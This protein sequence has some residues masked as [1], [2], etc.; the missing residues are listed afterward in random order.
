MTSG[1][2]PRVRISPLPPPHLPLRQTKQKKHFDAPAP[3]G[4]RGGGK[5][6]E[7]RG[8][9]GTPP[10]RCPRRFS[11]TLFPA[12]FQNASSFRLLLKLAV[13]H[14]HTKRKFAIFGTCDLLFLSSLSQFWGVR[15]CSRHI[16]SRS[17]SLF[18]F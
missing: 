1:T 2:Q 7:R 11:P 13:E 10:P 15:L 14:C 3:E 16:L 9:K 8:I 12:V 5:R 17:F 4:W 6:S 18:C